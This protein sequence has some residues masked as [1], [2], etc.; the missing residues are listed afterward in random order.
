[1]SSRGSRAVNFS[2]AIALVA[3][4]GCA[5]EHLPPR[6]TV[7]LMDDP[8]GLQ[9]VLARCNQSG[10]VY[11]DVECRHA[12]EAVER[13]EAAQSTERLKQKQADAQSEFERAR[14]ERRLRDERERQREEAKQKVDPYTMPL[15]R[16]PMSA[17]PQSTALNPD[18]SVSAG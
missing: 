3:I 7:E 9:A 17:P 10:N 5:E 13:L 4:A 8:V 6:S 12:R 14:E 2:V 1:M 16:D 15:V 18:E 11:D